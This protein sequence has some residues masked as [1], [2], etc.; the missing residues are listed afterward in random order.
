[1][2]QAQGALAGAQAGLQSTLA[3]NA[4]KAQPPKVGDLAG[5]EAAVTSARNSVQTAQQSVDDTV[6]KAPAEGTVATVSNLVG[7]VV[8]GGGGSSSS[9]GSSSSSSGSSGASGGSA[10]GGGG[11]SSTSSSTGSSSGSSSGL[12]TLTDLAGLQVKAGFTEVDA[13][14]LRQGQ[15]ATIVLNALPTTELAAHVL[16]IDTT[17]TVVSNVVT[18]NVLFTLDRLA[19]GV[20][21]GMTAT[22]TVVTEERDGVLQVPTAAVRGQGAN[23]TVTVIKSG[24]QVPT[25]VVT[26]MRGDSTTEIVSGL[27]EGDVIVVSTG[28]GLGRTGATTGTGGT[29]A[30]VGGGGGGGGFG[31]GG[32]GAGGGGRLGG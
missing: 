31:G 2:S 17:S 25:S 6:L 29:G 20:K 16:S 7:E 9:A 4:V 28:S 26:G 21:P 3:G 1:V 19:D 32:L 24:K 12:I 18:Y 8:G 30:R 27:N 15:P 5:A 13:A 14:K 11:G 22:T 10:G 23:A